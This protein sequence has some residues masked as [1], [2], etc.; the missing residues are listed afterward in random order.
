MGKKIARLRTEQKGVEAA[1]CDYQI[2]VEKIKNQDTPN[3]KQELRS[4]LRNKNRL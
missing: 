4:Y 2:M 3:F 1:L